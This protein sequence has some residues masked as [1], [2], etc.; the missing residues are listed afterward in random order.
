MHFD[1]HHRTKFPL[2]FGIGCLSVLALSFVLNPSERL[3]VSVTLLTAV[4]G[5]TAFLYSNHSQ[6]TALFRDLFREFNSRYD[7]LNERLNEIYNRPTDIPIEAIDRGLL[8]DY[9]NLCAEEQMFARAGCIDSSVW[10]A[11]QNG[12]RFFAQDPE[13]RTFWEQELGQDSYYDFRIPK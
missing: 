7:S 3:A 2:L 1:L 5:I 13:I 11:W 12:M 6:E 10:R 9:F 4:A 8:C